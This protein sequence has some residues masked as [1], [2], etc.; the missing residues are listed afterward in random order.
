[1]NKFGKRT[2]E[3]FQTVCE[4][5]EKMVQMAPELLLARFQCKDVPG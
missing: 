3:D 1:M 5:I 4:V 2:E